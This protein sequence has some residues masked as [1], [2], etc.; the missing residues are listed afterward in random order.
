MKEDIGTH[1]I[2]IKLTDIEGLTLTETLSISFEG[3]EKKNTTD[4]V[5]DEVLA[6][7]KNLKNEEKEK[8]EKL[9]E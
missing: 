2:S 8:K 9:A 1:E 5:P 3:K 4:Y 6:Y 7:M